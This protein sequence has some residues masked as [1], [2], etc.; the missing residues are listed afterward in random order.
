VRR[1]SLPPPRASGAPGGLDRVSALRAG[2]AAGLRAE[3]GTLADDW[4]RS[5]A[6]ARRVALSLVLVLVVLGSAF[7]GP[8]WALRD[9]TENARW[10]ASS[11]LP[12]VPEA[13]VFAPSSAFDD[14][15]NYFFHTKLE[16]R[17]HLDVDLGSVRALDSVVITNRVDCCTARSRDLEIWL[18]DDGRRFHEV[19]RRAHDDQ[20]RIWTAALRGQRARFVRIEIP[21]KDYLHLARVRVFGR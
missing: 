13:G 10:T 4:E 14:V 8:R 16:N 3:W 18:G 1:S 11:H 2:I 12:T 7:L 20:A 21:R 17:P 19:L 6:Q 15:P 5:A 9:L